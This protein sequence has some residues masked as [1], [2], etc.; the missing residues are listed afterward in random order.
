VLRTFA[1]HCWNTERLLETTGDAVW[2]RCEVMRSSTHKI[3]VVPLEIQMATMVARRQHHRLS[4]VIRSVAKSEVREGLLRVAVH[5]RGFADR[6]ASRRRSEDLLSSSSEP[7]GALV[8]ALAEFLR[9]GMSPHI[10][11]PLHEDRGTMLNAL[12]SWP[13]ATLTLTVGA[14][15]LVGVLYWVLFPALVTLPWVVERA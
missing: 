12:P 3:P 10:G 15:A 5:D 1:A 7:V 2:H 14:V 8:R 13:R 6:R 11:R 4:Q 9:I